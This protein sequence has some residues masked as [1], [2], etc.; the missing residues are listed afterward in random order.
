MLLQMILFSL[1]FMAELYSAVFI[2]HIFFP[3]IC[4][5]NLG[6]FHVWAIVNSAAVNSGVHVFFES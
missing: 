5:W 4:R 3:F 2:Y 6:C 1:L